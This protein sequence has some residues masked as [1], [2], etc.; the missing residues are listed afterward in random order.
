MKRFHNRNNWKLQALIVPAALLLFAIVGQR[1]VE[2]CPKKAPQGIEPAHF[3]LVHG[4]WHGAWA[5]YK[6]KTQLEAMGHV[7]SVVELPSHGID[8]T[9]PETVTLDDYTNRVVEAIDE[10]GEPVIL[11]GHSLAGIV[12]SGAAEAR[13]D[14]VEKLV[15]LAALLLENGVSV[16]DI[17]ALAPDA[18]IVADMIPGNGTMDINRDAVENLFYN[19][20]PKADIN[21]AESL[22]VVNPLYPLVTPISITEE[23]FGSVPRYYIATTDD[24][25]IPSYMQEYMYT[26]MP[27]E[28][29]FT[30]H[31]DHSPFFSRPERLTAI[32]QQIAAR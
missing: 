29:V 26:S 12:I 28:E 5:W 2:S 6:T 7:V 3:V 8:K 32:L 9:Q 23:N 22:V 13:P 27:C 1:S 25:A 15:Y 19:M 11:V 24:N 20:S 21:L 10:A 18:P 14:S 30:I 17:V 16:F 4:A 31:S